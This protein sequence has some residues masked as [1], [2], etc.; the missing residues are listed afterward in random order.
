MMGHAIQNTKS[1]YG[2]EGLTSHFIRTTENSRMCVQA[3]HAREACS[4]HASSHQAVG[5]A[6]TAIHINSVATQQADY[7]DYLIFKLLPII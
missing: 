2:M 3:F 4:G 7:S 5:L 6:C 1:T